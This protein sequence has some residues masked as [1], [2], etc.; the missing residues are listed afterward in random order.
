MNSREILHDFD[1]VFYGGVDFGSSV[2]VSDL[3]IVYNVLHFVAAQVKES[4]DQVTINET[5]KK[6]A[7]FENFRLSK[8]W[9]KYTKWCTKP[10]C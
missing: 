1:D 2:G 6:Y 9:K 5:L 10:T 4:L 8:F 3:Q 7:I